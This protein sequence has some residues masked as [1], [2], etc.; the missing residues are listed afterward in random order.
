MR[1]KSFICI[2][3][4]NRKPWEQRTR[5]HFIPQNIFGQFII[6]EV[7]GDCNSLMGSLVDTAFPKYIKHAN[8]LKTGIMETPGIAVLGDKSTIEGNV[9]IVEQRTGIG[10]YTIKRFTDKDG[11]FTAAVRRETLFLTFSVCLR[12]RL[13]LGRRF[14][15]WTMNMRRM[16]R[17]SNYSHS[18]VLPAAMRSR[19]YLS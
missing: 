3:C 6:R 2:Y 16:T 8:F 18:I 19:S 9:S 7:C 10:P 15:M 17:S 1:N 4:G 5:E 12:K 14:C 13:L 11:N